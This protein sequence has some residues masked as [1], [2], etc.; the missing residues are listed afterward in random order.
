MKDKEL[1]FG[2]PEGFH[3]IEEVFAFL[4]TLGVKRRNA[5]IIRYKGKFY[6]VMM[7]SFYKEIIIGSDKTWFR[8]EEGYF[9][10]K[11]TMS[12]KMPY[13]INNKRKRPLS[14]GIVEEMLRDDPDLMAYT[15]TYGNL[16]EEKD[17]IH[18]DNNNYPVILGLTFKDDFYNLNEIGLLKT[19]FSNCSIYLKLMYGNGIEYI[20]PFKSLA[21]KNGEIVHFRIV[22]TMDDYYLSL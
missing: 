6:G 19:Y 9:L 5:V 7:E 10:V 13:E 18:G 21:L 4:E 3:T 15:F 16:N 22:I 20:N 17:L 2:G 11:K 12:F 8:N 1:Y 14:R